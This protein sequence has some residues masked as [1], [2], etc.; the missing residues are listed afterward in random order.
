MRHL[1]VV[2]GSDRI[3]G[4]QYT[5]EKYNGVSGKGHGFYKFESID[6]VSSGA[7]DPDAGGVQAVS[8][9]R[10]RINAAENNFT[11]FQESA[12]SQMMAE[13][14]QHLFEDVRKGLMTDMFSDCPQCGRLHCKVHG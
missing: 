10:Q 13:D 7:R 9:T 4:Y 5:I 2:A 3:P 14:V 8:G 12:P 6:F 1:T 11:A